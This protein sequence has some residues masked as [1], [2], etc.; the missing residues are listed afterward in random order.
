M[1]LINSG[2]KI[3]AAIDEFDESDNGVLIPFLLY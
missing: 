3:A 1:F 2:H